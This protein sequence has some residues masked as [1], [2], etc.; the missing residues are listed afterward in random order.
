MK[1]KRIRFEGS[2]PAARPTS[3]PLPEY[4]HVSVSPSWSGYL[5]DFFP[6]ANEQF[7][8]TSHRLVERLAGQRSSSSLGFG[9]I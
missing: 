5:R 7:G 2:T 9:V 8:F 4:S 6:R 3:R 1:K